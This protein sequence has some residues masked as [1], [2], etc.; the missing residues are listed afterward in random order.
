MRDHARP[1]THTER[2]GQGGREADVRAPRGPARHDPLAAAHDERAILERVIE[3]CVDH[4]RGVGREHERLCGAEVACA[5]VVDE[6]TGDDRC[7]QRRERVARQHEAVRGR[8]DR[9]LELD[10]EVERPERQPPARV[11]VVRQGT[12]PNGV[13]V[14]RRGERAPHE[15]AT[16]RVGRSQPFEL[17]GEGKEA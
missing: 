15:G 8:V 5:A 17:L 4:R 16:H 13:D 2:V 1:V 10:R 9:H 12:Q 3:A 7:E 6:D 14:G 11:A